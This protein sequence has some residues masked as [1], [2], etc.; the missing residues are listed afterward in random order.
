M[1]TGYPDYTLE[2]SGVVQPAN[3]GTGRDSWLVNE[4]PLGNGNQP[5]GGATP[6]VDSGDIFQGGLSLNPRFYSSAIPFSV[7]P[8]TFGAPLLQLRA[9]AGAFQPQA[10]IQCE[11][12]LTHLYSAE[13]GLC[14]DAAEIVSTALAGDFVLLCSNGRVILASTGGKQVMLDSAGVQLPFIE[15]CNGLSTAGQGVPIIISGHTLQVSGATSYTVTLLASPPAVGTYRVSGFLTQVT[16]GGSG[17]MSI[18]VNF[19]DVTTAESITF[20]PSAATGSVGAKSQGTAFF[21]AISSASIVA[22][23]TTNNTATFI[24]ALALERV[25]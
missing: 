1:A 12:S 14:M 5:F 3:G 13:L 17:N 16:S 10:S 6:P 7:S 11:D 9:A 25:L 4:V 2:L 24:Y 20:A 21:R 8:Y 22:V 15:Q 19:N 23:L 18:A